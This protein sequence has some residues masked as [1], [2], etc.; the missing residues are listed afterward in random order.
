MVD[1]LIRLR[2]LIGKRGLLPVRSA[3]GFAGEIPFTFEAVAP[4]SHIPEETDFDTFNRLISRSDF[5]VRFDE[6]TA[7]D[8][9]NTRHV[10]G[11]YVLPERKALSGFDAQLS[12]RLIAK[13]AV[14][15][16]S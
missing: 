6:G 4:P 15:L 7:L 11:F 9:K 12:S 13:L 14:A 16:A 1:N 8:G 5:L 2:T 3:D 10:S